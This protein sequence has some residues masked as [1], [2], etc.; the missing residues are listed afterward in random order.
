MRLILLDLNALGGED[1]VD[2]SPLRE[3]GELEI[4]ETTNPLES[5]RRVERCDVLLTVGVPV[6]RMLLDWAPKIRQVVLLGGSRSLVD[7]TAVSDLE[8]ILTE[9]PPGEPDAMVAGAAEAIRA[10]GLP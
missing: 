4:H 8:V 10:A 3:V 2:L 9:I 7:M 6:S 5:F 1:S